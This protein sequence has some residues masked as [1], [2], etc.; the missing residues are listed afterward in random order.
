MA[1]VFRFI[2]IIDASAEL[3]SIAKLQYLL[4]S[5]K[6]DAALPFEH[7]P[8]TADNYSV[9]WAALLKR[10]D[11]TRLLIREYYRKLHFLSGVQSVCVNK[12]THLVD[13]FTRFVN[14]LVK[15]MEPVDSWDTPLSNMLLMI[16]LWNWIVKRYW[17]GKNTPCTSPR[18]DTKM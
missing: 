2:A 14:G 9:T 1:F 13:E 6:G 5:L 17:L 16:G 11:N 7:T 10:Y 3:P 12:L 8:L 4:S 15:L 18:I